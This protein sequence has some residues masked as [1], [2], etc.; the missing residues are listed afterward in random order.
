QV[1]M[2]NFLVNNTVA[3][4][5]EQLLARLTL[6]DLVASQPFDSVNSGA[7]ERDKLSI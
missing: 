4:L 2:E 5:A 7:E 6:V 1:P 3:R